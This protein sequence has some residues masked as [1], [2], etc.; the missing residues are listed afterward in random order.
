VNTVGL[1]GLMEIVERPPSEP[2]PE[3]LAI[4]GLVFALSVIVRVPVLAPIAAGV[5]VIE[6]VQLDAAANV[7]GDRGQVEV[8]AKSPEAEIPEIV[9]GTD[10]LFCTVT[11]LA[12]LVVVTV[13][14]EKEMVV[15][16]TVTESTPEP[17]NG[18]VCGLF[19]ASSLTVSVPV[20]LPVAV[21]VN[22]TETVQLVLAARLLGGEG[23]L[24]VCAKS[25]EVEMPEI[26]RGML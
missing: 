25:P 3:R 6:I 2:V 21:G 26:L 7:F 17:A 23:Q 4:C 13:W 20:L 1:L 22:V 16:T 12:E 8:C 10:W 14:L 5:K 9:N 15:G 11:V 19:G 18:A 24:E